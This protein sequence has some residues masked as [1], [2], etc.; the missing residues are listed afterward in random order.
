MGT[1]FGVSLQPG[2]RVCKRPGN[3]WEPASALIARRKPL[4]QA[5]RISS[6]TIFTLTHKSRRAEI[7][8]GGRVLTASGGGGGGYIERQP[9]R[10]TGGGGRVGIGM[11]ENTLAF[12]LM[13]VKR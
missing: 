11:H 13:R 3:K 12:D 2:I 8:A 9:A 10:R 5:T 4:A 1:F 6:A 7:E